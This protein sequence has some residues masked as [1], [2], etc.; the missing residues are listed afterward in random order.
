MQVVAIADESGVILDF[1]Q[2]KSLDKEM[3]ACLRDIRALL[4]TWMGNYVMDVRDDDMTLQ[5]SIMS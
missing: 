4:A 1:E 3:L 5:G 2:Q